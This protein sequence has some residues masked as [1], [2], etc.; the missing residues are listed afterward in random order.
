M[1][2]DNPVDF[3]QLE[4]QLDASTGIT[5]S[6]GLTNCQLKAEV[7]W[8]GIIGNIGLKIY[9]TNPNDPWVNYSETINLVDGNTIGERV[10][11]DLCNL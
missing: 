10:L 7:K 1:N 8:D 6:V 3:I 11:W 9:G 2:E 5:A 4:G